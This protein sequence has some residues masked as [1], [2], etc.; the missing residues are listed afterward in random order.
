LRKIECR[1]VIDRRLAAT[2]LHLALQI[3]LLRRFIGRVDT[4]RSL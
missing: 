4:S 2:Q 1:P 3:Q